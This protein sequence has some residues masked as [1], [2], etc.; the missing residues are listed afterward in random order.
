[1]TQIRPLAPTGSAP[2]K[3]TGVIIVTVIA[4]IFVI[5][6]IAM[7]EFS[8]RNT[9]GGYGFEHWTG[10]VDPE[11][12]RAYRPLFKGLTASLILSLTAIIIVLVLLLPTMLLVRIRFPKLMRWL[13]LICIVP[14]A[15]PAIALVVGFA[16]VY[17]VVVR[18]LGSGAWTLGLLYGVLVLPFASRAIGANLQAL[19]VVTLVE[20]ARSLGASWL[21]VFFGVLIPNLRRGILAAAFISLAV[22]LGEYT[23]ASLLNRPNLQVAIVAMGKSDPYVAVI[24]A[25]LALVFVT[26][27]LLLI[28]TVAAPKSGRKRA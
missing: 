7:I 3:R 19:D 17:G 18:L 16:P 11:N 21:R 2:R 24:F 20:A 6:I 10:L 5:P 1:M 25:L 13:E 4:V 9:T 27:L 14:I 15:V 23:V 22:V 26:V 8:L 12:E 28:G